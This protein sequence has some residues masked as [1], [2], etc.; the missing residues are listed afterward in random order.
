LR[1]MPFSRAAMV[2]VL[3]FVNATLPAAL[4]LSSLPDLP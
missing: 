1:V 2:L 3:P 4:H